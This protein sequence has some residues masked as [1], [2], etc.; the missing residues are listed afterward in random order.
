MHLCLFKHNN[1]KRENKMSLYL[2]IGTMM[3]LL[4]GLVHLKSS[5]YV[6]TNRGWENSVIPSFYQQAV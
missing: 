3:F 1:I 4:P 2:L 5:N 6:Y